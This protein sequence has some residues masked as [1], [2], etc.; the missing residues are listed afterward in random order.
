MIYNIH[1]SGIRQGINKLVY[2]YGTYN[3][4]I[5]C[6]PLHNL[7]IKCEPLHDL[8]IRCEPLF[9]LHIKFEPL[10]IRL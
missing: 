10:H 7:H 2:Y 6:E 8:H 4:H 5:K 1:Y 3:L 9:N